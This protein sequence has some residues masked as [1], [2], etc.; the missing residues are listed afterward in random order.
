MSTLPTYI[1]DF[2]VLIIGAGPSGATTAL[3]LARL[4]IKS[5]V[6]S[7]HRDTA[8]TPRAHIFNQRAMEVLRDA[9]LEQALNG[10][11]TPAHGKYIHSVPKVS[12]RIRFNTNCTAIL[13]MQHTS[14]LNTL[15][16]EEYGRLWAWGNNPSQKGDYEAASPCVMSDLPQSFLE[17]I[18]VAEAKLA[19]AEFRFSTE[20]LY[21]ED[22]VRGVM[23]TLRD[24]STTEEYIINSQYLIGADGA[25]SA[26]LE[27]LKIPVIGRQLNNAFNV[28]IKADLTKYIQ[29][30]PGSLNWVLNPDAPEW[31]AVGNFRMVRPWNEWVI[32][33][34]P[35]RKDTG[36]AH[37]S[38]DAIRGRIC[39]MIGND[40]TDIE[41]LSTF[42][43]TIND[44]VAERWQSGRVLCIGD[45]THR[46]PPINGLGSNTCISDA[47]NLAWKLAYVVKGWAA[48]S[49]LDTLTIERKPVGDGVVRRANEGMEAHRRL[50]AIIGLTPESRNRATALLAAA[51]E[52]GNKMR[53]A[54][55]HALEATEDEVQALGIQMNQVY[56]HSP[57]VFAE[58]DDDPPDFTHLNT[59]RQ[60]MYSTYPGYHLP[61]VW[62]AAGGQ[63]PRISILDLCGQGHFTLFTG[64][65]GDAW[66]DAARSFSD[67]DGL[68][69]LAYKIGFR[70][71]Y[72][73]CYRDWFRYR[74]VGE[75]GAVLVRPD[76]FVA[77]RCKD[78]D[79]DAFGKL[80]NA[81]KHILGV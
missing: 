30:R 23:T 16:G 28:H 7:R 17:P 76:H 71:D 70:C 57:G 55:R 31:S 48:R 51:T 34:H 43:W 18:L 47:F 75:K 20:F 14:W 46:H 26:V 63:S 33:M 9:G 42:S 67:P 24:R 40:E 38:D 5:L 1:M 21:F 32:S 22:T 45:A 80:T 8:N 35:A 19:G 13:D 27:A 52:D 78:M 4:G 81:M 37:P 61:H 50:W 3:L 60:V 39:Q 6:I 65:G 2:P 36:S 56:T 59:L 53:D 49:L 79:D 11:A 69:V 54:F 15:A 74:G 41:I 29:H 73:D 68:Q 64:I 58:V 66:I 72:M 62:L 44:Q 25:R 12:S 77:W 10:I